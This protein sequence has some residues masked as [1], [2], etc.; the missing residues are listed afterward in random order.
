MLD[1][2]F[3]RD[4]VQLLIKQLKTND[5]YYQ[6]KHRFCHTSFPISSELALYIF[7]DALLKFKIIIDNV[8]LLPEYL[9]QLEKL[10]RKL[11]DFDDV[12]IGIHKLITRMTAIQYDIHDWKQDNREELIRIVYNKYVTNG[13][14]FHG[15][16]S[17]YKKSIQ[18]LGFVPESYENYYNRF[19]KINGIFRK[20]I[21]TKDFTEKTV[22]FCDDSV[23]GCYYSMYAPMYYFQLLTN[24]EILGKKIREDAYLKGDYLT[25]ISPLKRFMDNNLFHEKKKKFVLDLVKNEWD[26]LQRG[27]KEICLLCVPRNKIIEKETPI[28]HF[29]NSYEDV[30]EIVDHI[31]SSKYN[32]VY[33]NQILSKEDIHIIT[34]PHYYDREISKDIKE[35][36]DVIH[37]EKEFLSVYGNV[38]F[39]LIMGSFFISFGVILMMIQMLGG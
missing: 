23:L 14:F 11:S 15:F 1:E 28:Q 38:S 5:F 26:I 25:L 24:T 16:P 13:Y 36:N 18:E 8:Y 3:E 10:Y 35:K 39:L 9:E 34:C 17:S 31:L 27:N 7:Y 32:N 4:D 29:L 21:I 30:F 12:R 2:Y 20:N 6:K 19:D 33:M 22:A 37:L